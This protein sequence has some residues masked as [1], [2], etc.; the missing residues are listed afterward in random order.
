MDEDVC[1]PIVVRVNIFF[2]HLAS[3]KA[4]FERIRVIIVFIPIREGY[5]RNEERP[6]RPSSQLTGSVVFDTDKY[7]CS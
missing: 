2:F 5:D 7:G 3:R 4:G 6:F 1:F